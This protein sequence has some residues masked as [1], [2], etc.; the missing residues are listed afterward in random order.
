MLSTS[1]LKS[2]QAASYFEKDDYYSHEDGPNHSRWVGKGAEQL[3]L[4]G[5]VDQ[6]TFQKV[7]TGK[8]AGGQ[9]LFNRRINPA[10]RRAATDFTFSAP[11]SVMSLRWF[12]VISGL[13]KRIVWP[14][15][16][17]FRYWSRA[18]PRQG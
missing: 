13:L 7:L 3:D 6:E 17:R 18:M 10:K 15:T 4:V 16:G 5:G 2:A 9:P 11:K 12:R 1:N 14:L 8:S